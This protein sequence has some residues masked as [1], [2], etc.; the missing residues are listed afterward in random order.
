MR[1]PAHLAY[2]PHL[3]TGRSHVEEEVADPSVSIRLL[4][5]ARKQDAPVAEVGA[6]RPNLLPVDDPA[7]PVAL[8]S[9]RQ[10]GEVGPRPGLAEQLAP[11]FVTSQHRR[12]E[13]IFL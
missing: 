1:G 2:R 11:D 8:R 13:A 5:G 6:R 9:R 10:A 12:Q 3:D 7:F 4:A